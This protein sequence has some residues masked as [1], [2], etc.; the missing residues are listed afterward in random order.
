MELELFSGNGDERTA[1]KKERYRRSE[2]DSY[3]GGRGVEGKS[4]ERAI[5]DYLSPQLE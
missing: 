3:E 1:R 2:S 4:A 5:E